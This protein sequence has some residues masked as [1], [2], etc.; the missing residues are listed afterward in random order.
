MKLYMNKVKFRKTELSN[1]LKVIVHEDK[2]TPMALINILYDVGAKDEDPS[3]TGFA[4]LFEHLMFG[5]SINIP[6]YEAPLQIVGGENNA[7]TSNDLTN[8]Y[9]QIPAVNLETG[10]WLESDRMLSLA[11]SEKSLE[12]Q[13]NVVCEE[14]KQRYLNQPYGDVWL[15]LRPVIYE[16]HPYKWPTIG[17]ELRHIEE[18]NMGQVKAFFKK[19]YSPKNAIL[20]VAGGVNFKEV[21]ALAE[22]YFGSIDG[23]KRYNREL[24]TEPAQKAL[25]RLEIEGDVPADMLFMA[26]K[27]PDRMHPDY[28]SCDLI[29]DVLGN[30]ESSR[31][32]NK[33]LK[34]NPLF[35]ELSAYIMGSDETGLLVISGR[36]LN[37]VSFETAEDAIRAELDLLI[38]DGVGNDEL[39][40]VKN[41]V[42]SSFI[43]GNM[44]LFNKAFQLAYYEL[45]GDANLVNEEIP[46]YRDVSTNDIK[47]M[48]K[49]ILDSSQC[50]ILRYSRK[51]K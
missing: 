37:T 20:V 48:S 51:D 2:S 40:K 12:V 32:R 50:T 24:P 10:F 1:G 3:H 8:Y 17:K 45:K 34:E 6:D 15:K 35:S 27:M 7:F 33:F 46:K 18:A 31:L 11:F 14:F 28:H 26:F 5:G 39:E 42:E 23:G 49:I 29:S 43:F 30:G 19:H 13:K 41:K 25:R 4:H 47:K 22:K 9:M 21:F 44:D 16:K 36:L 38:K